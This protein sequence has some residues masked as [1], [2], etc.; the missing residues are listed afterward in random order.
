[1]QVKWI[2]YDPNANPV[3][4]RVDG[5]VL[6]GMGRKQCCFMLARDCDAVRN[7]GT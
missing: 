4:V 1:M 5:Q 7:N 6:A 3:K 2:I